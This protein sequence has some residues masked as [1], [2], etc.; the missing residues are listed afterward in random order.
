MSQALFC[1]IS[2]PESSIPLGWA[3]W[4]L[5]MDEALKLERSHA[6]GDPTGGR[7]PSRDLGLAWVLLPPYPLALK[8]LVSWD[9]LSPS[10]G[11][12]QVGRPASSEPVLLYG[13]GSWCPRVAGRG[14]R[15]RTCWIPLACLSRMAVI[16]LQSCGGHTHIPRTNG[17]PR[18]PPVPSLLSSIPT[19]V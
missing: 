7:W 4:L 9:P 12:G 3:L 10:V 13:R 18:A 16:C 17:F 1:R 11:V 8:G 19:P 6:A 15:S 2:H 14:P 5:L